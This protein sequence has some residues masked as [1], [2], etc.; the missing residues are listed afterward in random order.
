M[1]S[2]NQL[3]RY[4]I[5]GTL[6]RGAMGVVYKAHDPLIE[7]T[8]AIKTISHAGLTVD[9]S[10]DFRQ[11]FFLEAKSAGRLNHPSIVTIHDIGNADDLAFIAM[12]LLA[13]QSL[14]DILDSGV[15]LPIK[16]IAHIAYNVADGLAFAHASGVVHRDIKPANIMVQESG[17]AKITDFGIALLPS[18]AQTTAGTIIGSP[19]YMAPEQVLGHKADCRSDIF[20]LG[21]VIYEM[22]TGRPPFSGPDINATLY[23]VLNAV[24]PLPSDINPSLP[25]G[26][27]R[28]V[29]RA[30]AKDPDKRYQSAKEMAKDLRNYKKLPGLM[31]KTD[32]DE[33]SAKTHK[34]TQPVS[35]SPSRARPLHWM[36]A[37]GALVT[38]LLGAYLW[39]GR[40]QTPILPLASADPLFQA[41]PAATPAAS[42]KATSA[43]ATADTRINSGSEAEATP[44]PPVL[45]PTEKPAAAKAKA[46]R[47]ERLK[48]EPVAEPPPAPLPAKEIP[49][50]LDWKA[51]LRSELTE[52]KKLSFFSRISCGEKAVWKHCPGHWG[53]IEECP[54]QSSAAQ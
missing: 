34:A 50:A 15:V 6:G 19:K 9:E 28:I 1:M 29:A 11:R 2:V 47:K 52:C 23:Q 3:G 18:G 44:T 20:S 13:G 14:R 36:L 43:P 40:T 31:R 24:P 16:T 8:V 27:D 26:F 45:A 17:R 49:V 35:P 25:Q 33:G 38:V 37:L 54:G 22:L 21:A 46:P 10:R 4:E 30:L 42:I 32:A 51:Q 48:A 12:E 39:Q 41:E 53:S 5:L 7:R